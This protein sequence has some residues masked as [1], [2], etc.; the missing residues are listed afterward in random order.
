MKIWEVRNEESEFVYVF[1]HGLHSCSARERSQ[2]P[3]NDLI[4]AFKNNS[5]LRPIQAAIQL[6]VDV[7]RGDSRK[8]DIDKL[9]SSLI[10]SKKIP[11]IKQKA[12]Q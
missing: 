8:K 12:E 5:S 2:P 6:L 4:K 7:T 11:N 10:D 3:E 9:T 1:H